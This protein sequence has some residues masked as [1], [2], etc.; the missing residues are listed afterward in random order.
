MA[1][2]L[3]IV[4]SFDTTGSI[5]PAL[6]EIR[7]KVVEF[8]ESLFSAI[9]T[10][11]IGIIAHGDYND[12]Y[13]T[14]HLPLTQNQRHI[15]QFVQTVGQ[16]SGFGNGGE[17]Y[18]RVLHEARFFDWQATKRIMVLIGDEP[19]H[20]KGKVVR[21]GYKFT[22]VEHDWVEETNLLNASGI[23]V[24]PIRV[25]DRS[26]SKDFHHTLAAM[27]GVPL[28]RLQQFSNIVP[29]LT[30]IVYK[31]ESDERLESYGNEL[32]LTGLLDR[33]LAETFN[34]LLG[35]TNVIGGTAYSQASTD[36]EAVDPTRFQ[37]LHIDYNTPI[38]EFVR[39]TGARFKIGQGFYELTKREKVQ[40]QKEVVLRTKQGDMFTGAKA[41]EMIGLPY[42][43]R[44]TV[45]P[46]RNLGYDVFIQ[47]TS[48]NRKL[49]AGTR[50]LY[51]VESY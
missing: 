1:N 41:R 40:E 37:M 19:P 3:D 12:T 43:Q 10:L 36:L 7:R 42:G 46:L 9:P 28:L 14:M 50:F 6:A 48:A 34:L 5:Y 8:T 20:Y 44:G 31:Q 35:V 23:T 30:G 27:N 25:M 18:E 16:T 13:E 15:A 29:I 39:S 33:N 26:D 21:G 32:E 4:I 49:I 47:S 51:E 22:T 2:D 17:L 38:N 11:R 45:S 24:Y